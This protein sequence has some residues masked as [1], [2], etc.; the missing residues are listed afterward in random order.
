MLSPHNTLHLKALRVVGIYIRNYQ[1]IEAFDLDQEA[2]ADGVVI[3]GGENSN[4]KTSACE[5]VSIGLGLKSKQGLKVPVNKNAPEDKGYGIRIELGDPELAYTI[6]HWSTPEGKAEGF[7][8]ARANGET[9][10]NPQ[11]WMKDVLDGLR[12]PV[13]ILKMEPAELRKVLIQLGGLDLD[14]LDKAIADAKAIEKQ[15]E[16]TQ[17]AA[18]ARAKEFPWHED[19]PEEETSA[20][21]LSERLQEAYAEN[22]RRQSAKDRMTR[23]ATEIARTISDNRLSSPSVDPLVDQLVTHLR[24]E[25]DAITLIDTAALQ[26]DI[27][28]VEGRNRKFRDNQARIRAN[29]EWQEAEAKLGEAIEARKAAESA[30]RSAIANATFPVEGLGFDEKEVTYNGIPFSQAGNAERIRVAV[31]ICLAGRG[32][33]PFLLIDNAEALDK[34]SLRLLIEEVDRQGAQCLAF[35]V[36]NQDEDETFDRECAFYIVDGKVKKG[37]Q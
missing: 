32:A 36:A 12:N 2:L 7:R 18:L 5:A 19:A 11:T 35:V 25:A 29:K 14:A 20:A 28:N 3:V 17:N 30:K 31:A 23:G 21:E 15:A 4:G 16:L 34:K 27:A 26:A 10:S 24:Q 22:Q 33:L 6:T 9:V 37:A 13:D 1:R 8:V